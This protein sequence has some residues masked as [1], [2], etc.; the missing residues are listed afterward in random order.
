MAELEHGNILN[1]YTALP[2]YHFMK[3]NVLESTWYMLLPLVSN[4]LFYWIL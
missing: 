3:K 2:R 1:G 4:I